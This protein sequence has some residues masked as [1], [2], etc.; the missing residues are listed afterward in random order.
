M[1]FLQEGLPDLGTRKLMFILVVCMCSLLC[2]IC[3]TCKCGVVKQKFATQPWSSTGH[4]GAVG[5]FFFFCISDTSA[6]S[7]ELFIYFFDW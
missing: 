3:S 5:F 6:V 4:T 2:A 1:Y 7:C